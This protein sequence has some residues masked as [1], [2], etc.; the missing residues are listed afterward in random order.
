MIMNLA[1]DSSS[2][3][4]RSEEEDDRKWKEIEKA[5]EINMLLFLLLFL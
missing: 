2:D 3:S 4:G 5:F 1:D